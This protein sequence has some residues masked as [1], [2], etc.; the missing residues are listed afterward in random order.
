M[1]AKSTHYEASYVICFIAYYLLS[2]L[3]QYSTQ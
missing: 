2:F 3:G 1:M